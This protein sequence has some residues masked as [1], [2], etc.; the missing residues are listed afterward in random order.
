MASA[1]LDSVIPNVVFGGGDERHFL[2]F[3]L[4]VGADGR[5]DVL[6]QVSLLRLGQPGLYLGGVALLLLLVLHLAEKE[7][8]LKLLPGEILDVLNQIGVR[9][10]KGVQLGV[11][12]GV[13]FELLSQFRFFLW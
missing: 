9:L 12:F 5:F 7:F 6:D 11:D 8:P 4:H 2:A 1:N 3:G 10:H 13:D